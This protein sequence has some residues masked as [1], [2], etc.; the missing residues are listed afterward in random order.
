MDMD[1]TPWRLWGA[2]IQLVYRNFPFGVNQTELR[3]HVEPLY[4]SVGQLYAFR[5][6]ID[7]KGYLLTTVTDGNITNQQADLTQQENALKT[8]LAVPYGN[9]VFK[10]DSGVDSSEALLN[11]QSIEGVRI[12]SGPH[13]T[14]TMGPE[15]CTVRT[16]EFTAEAETSAVGSANYALSFQETLR[17]WGGGPVFLFKTAI[18]GPPQKQ[19]PIQAAPYYASQQ[20][21]IVGYRTWLPATPPKA[22][23]ALLKAPEI[24][25]SSPTR[26]APFNNGYQGFETTYQYEF[27]SAGPLRFLPT[28]WRG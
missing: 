12:T 14:T 18:N 27:G 10:Q 5:Q 3:T 25:Q 16:F 6:V 7:V 1:G 2:I 23:Q 11:A 15:Y 9:L 21:T 4:S 8:A 13:F 26:R 28:L 22:P 17:F 19:N 24:S 20:G